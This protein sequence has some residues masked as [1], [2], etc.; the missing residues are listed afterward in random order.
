M[1]RLAWN[2][3]RGF[4]RGLLSP[5]SLPY[6]AAE[7]VDALA[8][9]IRRALIDPGRFIHEDDLDAPAANAVSLQSWPHE[10]HI[11]QG[12]AL[13]PR[14]AEL[15]EDPTRWDMG[16]S[17]PLSPIPR[18]NRFDVIVGANSDRFGVPP[19]VIKAVIATESSF[20][21]AAIREE[22]RIHDR[23]RGLMQVLEGTARGLGYTG[24][25]KLIH[26]PAVGIMLGA[27]LLAQL[28]A[29]YGNWRDALAAYN[30]GKPRK[31]PDGALVPEL[32]AYVAKVERNMMRFSTAG[33]VALG[34]V[35]VL[36]LAA[37]AFLA[38]RGKGGAT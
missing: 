22:P 4:A 9:V 27:M 28:K 37:L 24:D 26:D 23:S 7:A 1:I 11:G 13:E 12:A 8:R 6:V 31:T 21:P 3:L 19:E 16:T 15:L 2:I 5:A 14:V 20:N 33:T 32:A 17:V 35:G 29:K 10:V 36:A 30:G 34:G 38:F 18:E 25:P